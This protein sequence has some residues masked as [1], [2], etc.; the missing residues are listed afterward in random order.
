MIHPDA[1]VYPLCRELAGMLAAGHKEAMNIR[2]SQYCVEREAEGKPVKFWEQ[3]AISDTVRG[4]VAGKSGTLPSD[5]HA[6]GAVSTKEGCEP[7]ESQ[8]PST[9]T[10]RNTA[11]KTRDYECMN[12]VACRAPFA[13]RGAWAE[14]DAS[15]L[16]GLM[17]L[18]REGDVR[19]FGYL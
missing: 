16:D 19:Y 13:P 12:V 3:A 6:T 7:S 1:P 4:I 2:W 9:K 14:C 17:Q 10:F 18:W 11:W 8:Q 15:V 5:T